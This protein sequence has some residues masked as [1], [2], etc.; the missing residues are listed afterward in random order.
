MCKVILQGLWAEKRAMEANLHLNP[1]ALPTRTYL[2]STVVPL[3]YE[4]MQKCVYERP[5]NPAEF[6]AYYLLQKNPFT[7]KDETK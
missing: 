4:A 2:D 7:K 5:A 3:L 6:V 1:K